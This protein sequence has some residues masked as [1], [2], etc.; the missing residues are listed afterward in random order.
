MRF[1]ILKNSAF[2]SGIE[3]SIFNL[4]LTVSL[5]PYIMSSIYKMLNLSIGCVPI[6]KFLKRICFLAFFISRGCPHCS[7]HSPL[8]PSANLA[9]LH[10]SEPSSCSHVIFSLHLGKFPTYKDFKL[11]PPGEFGTPLISGS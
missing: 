2:S 7:T 5:V 10:L 3:Q 8:S 6:L 1:V 11:R 4:V 9:T